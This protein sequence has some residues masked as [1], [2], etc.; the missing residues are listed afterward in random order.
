M[1]TSHHWYLKAQARWQGKGYPQVCVLQAH[2][3]AAHNPSPN[4]HEVEDVGHSGAVAQEAADA[5]LEHDG[6]HQ[7]PVPAGGAG[8]KRLRLADTGQREAVRSWGPAGNQGTGSD[9][10]SREIIEHWHG[11]HLSSSGHQPCQHHPVS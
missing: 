6:D 5:D 10:S 7:D 1:G 4:G 9:S 2:P 8:W 11:P 3:N